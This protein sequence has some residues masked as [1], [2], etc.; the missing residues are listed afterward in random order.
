MG[1]RRSLEVIKMITEM[2][3]NRHTLTKLSN[4]I[5]ELELDVMSLE[6]EWDSLNA[7]GGLG[8]DMNETEWKAR[9]EYIL[10]LSDELSRSRELV[11]AAL[12]DE[13]NEKC[14]RFFH[15]KDRRLE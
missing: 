15:P 9:Q 13:W 10:K 12:D 7:S 3:T 2:T 14:I 1:N 4:L 6:S 8:W 5:L 11:F